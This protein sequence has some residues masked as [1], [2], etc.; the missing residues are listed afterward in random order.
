MLLTPNGTRLLKHWGV[1]QDLW[2]AANVPSALSVHRS[3][4][5]LLVREAEF[6]KQL[7]T[8]YRAPL[9]SVPHAAFQAALY[10]RAKELGVRFRVGEKVVSIE[11]PE[12][13]ENEFAGPTVRTHKRTTYSGDLIFGADGLHSVTRECIMGQ[14]AQINA[15]GDLEYALTL[16]MDDVDDER[17]VEWLEI[18]EV[19]IWI[20]PGTHVIAVP[21]E[22]SNGYHLLSSVEES[23][24]GSWADQIDAREELVRILEGWDPV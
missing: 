2:D 7:I 8:R 1:P 3:N 20:G 23:G 9:L 21:L 15:S 24:L 14:A 11:L 13:P 17:L 5:S 10:S 19:R 4:G 22:D 16:D 18:P 6:G 12:D